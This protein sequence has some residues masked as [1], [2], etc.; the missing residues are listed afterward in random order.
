MKALVAHKQ[1]RED[2]YFRLNVLRLT[3]PPLRKR[4]GDIALIAASLLQR[5]ALEYQ[6]APKQLSR[7]GLDYLMQHN[8]P[9]NI[10][11]LE[12]CLL[13]AFLLSP[14]T[15]LE[16][17]ESADMDAQIAM[18]TVAALD[19]ETLSVPQKNDADIIPPLSFQDAKAIAI[20]EFEANYLRRVMAIARGNV[21]AAAR[22]A[23]KERRAMGK[24]LQK[25]AIDKTQFQSLKCAS[26]VPVSNQVMG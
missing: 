2:L 8:W 15:I 3:M 23:G 10:R 11:E 25:Y 7:P 18:E 4:L 20:T 22:I 17:A 5:F 1:F 13:R 26:S 16:F 12:N 14:G 24:L 9:G 21:S 6:L 19:E